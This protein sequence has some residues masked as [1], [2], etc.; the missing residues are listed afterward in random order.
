MR[1]MLRG[2]GFTPV[3]A[4]FSDPSEV[5]EEIGE[6]CETLNVQGS[7]KVTQSVSAFK[8]RLPRCSETPIG[9]SMLLS[10]VKMGSHAGRCRVSEGVWVSK[11][12]GL[13]DQCPYMQ[14]SLFQ[15]REIK[16]L[17]APGAHTLLEQAGQATI[18][19]V[20][21][22]EAIVGADNWHE[23]PRLSLEMSSAS[24][25]IKA[26]LHEDRQVMTDT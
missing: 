7:G 25:T 21:Q 24:Q 2:Y 17:G 8:Q 5:Y 19:Y 13:T 20:V 9:P 26:A 15:L 4:A 6:A 18:C 22:D 14:G 10:R 11:G 1:D 16:V 23:A 12:L 3:H